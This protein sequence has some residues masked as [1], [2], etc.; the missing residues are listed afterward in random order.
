VIP[1]LYRDP[2]SP[3]YSL[4]LITTSNAEYFQWSPEH[5][6]NT[7]QVATKPG[8]LIHGTLTYNGASASSYTLK[9]ENTA[10]GQVSQGV[11]PV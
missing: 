9:N 11:I 6:V 8:D 3:A 4:S 5:N 7:N 2:C 1:P 10:T